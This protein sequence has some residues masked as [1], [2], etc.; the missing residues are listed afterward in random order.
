MRG[1]ALKYVLKQAISQFLDRNTKDLEVLVNN[2]YK[3][4]IEE[5]EEESNSLYKFTY[6]DCSFG[7]CK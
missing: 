5:Q 7:Q 3:Q 4:A 1:E 2:E 6:K